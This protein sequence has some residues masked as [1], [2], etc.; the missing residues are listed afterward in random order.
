MEQNVRL[1]PWYIVFSRTMAWLPVFFLFFSQHLSLEQVLQ[2]EA[3]YYVSVVILE[4]PS[5]YFSDAIGRRPTLLISSI[6]LA[7]AYAVFLIGDNFLVFAIAQ[8]FLAMGFA[9]SSGTDTSFHYDSLFGLGQADQ[10][11]QREAAVERNGFVASAI[12]VFI[13][14]LIGLIDLRMAYAISLVGALGAVVVVTRFQEPIRHLHT[15]A[16]LKIMGQLQTCLRY[17][18]Q[19]A[20]L[21]LFI[22]AVLMTILNH[23][24]YE[25]YQPYL[26]LLNKSQF[27]A[28]DQT[29]FAAGIV[30]GISMIFGASAANYSIRLSNRFGIG[31]TLLLAAGLQ[32]LI[33]IVMG[34][35]L[36]PLVIL[37]IINRAIPFGLMRAP[38]NAA[39]APKIPQAQRASYL[40]IQSLMGRLAFAATLFSLSILTGTNADPD[41]PTLAMMLRL[42]ALLGL[43]GLA[44][45]ALKKRHLIKKTE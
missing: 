5:G 22:F 21:W 4:V 2:I 42:T 14:G 25:F 9:F 37:L 23:I 34:L 1:Y 39:I 40:S 8:F 35:I 41:W 32:T 13:G 16:P 28:A 43:F 17:I 12:A 7:L 20:L 45:L 31:S 44:G 11:G 19:P 33:I 15:N 38:M 10:Y 26:D 6:A 29:S 3:F 27:M 30:M 18:Q 24:P 36:H